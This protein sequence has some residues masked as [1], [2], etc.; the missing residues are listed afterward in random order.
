[1]TKNGNILVP[2]WHLGYRIFFVVMNILSS[3]NWV[4]S[5]KSPNGKLNLFIQTTPNFLSIYTNYPY[6]LHSNFLILNNEK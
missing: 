4:H 2:F 6:P 5:F 3:I 1:M